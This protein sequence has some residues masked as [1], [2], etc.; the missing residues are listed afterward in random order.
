MKTRN[1]NVLGAALVAALALGA[2]AE[3]EP[4]TEYRPVV[5]PQRTNMAAFERDLVQCRQVALELEADYRKRQQEQAGQQMMVGLI[6]GALVG[7]AAGTNSG[8]QG[9][10]IAYGAATGAAAGAASTD[11]TRDLVRYGPRRV[12]DRCMAER[13]HSILNDIGRG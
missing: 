5:D 6:A 8:N 13:G 2:C 7:A 3:L 12:V 1:R 9:E 11:Y 4:L 10:L